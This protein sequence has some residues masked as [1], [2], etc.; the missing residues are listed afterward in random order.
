MLSKKKLAIVSIILATVLFFSIL[1]IGVGIESSFDTEI[2]STMI[3][4][5]GMLIIPFIALGLA[6][7]T[8]KNISN[9]R[10]VAVFIFWFG[11]A[12]VLY[13]IYI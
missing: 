6:K 2:S 13:S 10:I 3:I 5:V 4:I 8:H 1:F 9:K 11:L 7:A 12:I